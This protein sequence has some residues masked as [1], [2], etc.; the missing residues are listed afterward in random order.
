M[1]IKS[2]QQK[3]FL[4]KKRAWLRNQGTKK[5]NISPIK[6]LA[7]GRFVLIQRPFILTWAFSGALNTAFE[8]NYIAS[9]PSSISV[10][11]DGLFAAMRRQ[12]FFIWHV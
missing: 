1:L 10:S 2:S 4:L 9:H 5:C 8:I 6:R 12:D 11:H 7:N 3:M